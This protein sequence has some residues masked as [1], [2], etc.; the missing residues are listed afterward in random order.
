MMLTLEDCI[1]LSE[2]TEEEV[3]AIAEHEHIPTIV[4]AELGNYLVHS[5]EGT[6]MIRRI[7]VDHI[8]QA[9]AREDYAKALR[10]RLVLRHFIQTHPD[11]K[12]AEKQEG[13][14]SMPSE[15]EEE[16]AQEQGEHP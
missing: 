1:A 14:E 12:P 15:S 10:L 3:A 13:G 8:L 7:I 4:A 16:S 6:P 11:Y 2:L 5:P 9:E